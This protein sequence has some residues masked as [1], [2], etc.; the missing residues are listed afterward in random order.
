MATRIEVF[1]VTIPAGTAQ[2]TPVTVSLPFD[3]GELERI[4]M[5]WPPGP[6]GL[7]GLRIRHSSQVVIPYS[8]NSWVVSD[9]EPIYW[10]VS[11]YPATDKW[12]VLGYNLGVYPHTIQIRLLVNDP[13]RPP[14]PPQLISI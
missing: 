3:D 7:V 10:N 14:A 4:E 1:D 12:D 5:R 11:G 6:A 9:D 13:I 2:A 8:V